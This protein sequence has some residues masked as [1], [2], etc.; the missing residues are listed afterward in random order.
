MT[1]TQ[2]PAVK[3]PQI[4]KLHNCCCPLRLYETFSMVTSV[5]YTA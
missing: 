5:R 1:I 2:I 4:D 3:L